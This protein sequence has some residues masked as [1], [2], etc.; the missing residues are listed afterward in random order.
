MSIKDGISSSPVNSL[1]TSCLGAT[2]I[3]W[4]VKFWDY[5]DYSMECSA[6]NNE[7]FLS[8]RMVDNKVNYRGFL[9]LNSRRKQPLH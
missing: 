4:F 9:K 1:M 3:L 6:E 7:P 8:C 5:C 2:L